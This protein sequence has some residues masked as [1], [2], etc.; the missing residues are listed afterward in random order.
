[1]VKSRRSASAFQ[2]RPNRDLGAA[3]VGFD[4]RAQRR[5]LI[6]LAVGDDRDRAVLD[7][8]RHRLEA[9]RL[10]A[11]D[12]FLR[13]SRGRDVDVGDGSPSRRCAPRR[14]RC[15]PPR[16]LRQHGQQALQVAARSASPPGR[17]STL[18]R[19]RIEPFIERADDAGGHAPDALSAIGHVVVR[20]IPCSLHIAAVLRRWLAGSIRKRSGTSKTASTSSSLMREHEARPHDAEHRRDAVAA[21]GDIVRHAADDLDM[22]PR[23]GRSPRLSRAAPLLPARRRS[24]RCGRPE[25]PPGPNGCA[26]SR[27]AWSA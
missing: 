25:T 3:A 2:S 7:A 15:A 22:R 4:I 6:G 12:G 8:S 20:T 9:G 24:G 23:P 26:A 5:H 13:Y 16:R 19:S 21:A 10:R 14:R 17:R 11:P 1:M 27:P 18:C